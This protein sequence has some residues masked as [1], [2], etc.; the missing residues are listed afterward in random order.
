MK[1]LAESCWVFLGAGLGAN[2]RY[3]LSAMIQAR[4][5]TPFPW[6]TFTINVTGCF[7]IGLITGVLLAMD[8]GAP[9]RLLIVVGFL[10]GYTTFSSFSNETF[11]LIQ[12]GN[13]VYAAAYVLGSVF[14]GLLGTW[15]GD[16]LIKLVFRG[17]P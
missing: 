2:V 4:N 15:L 9:W 5:T 17:R 8:L 10:G 13:M 7:G 3:W 11:G 14:V 16:I 1:G 6:G 12:R